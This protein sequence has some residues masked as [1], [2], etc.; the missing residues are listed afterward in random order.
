M[1]EGNDQ[2]GIGE[3]LAEVD[4]FA[5]TLDA[6]AA[7]YWSL[8]RKRFAWLA[9]FSCRTAPESS[10]YRLLDVGNSFQTVLLKALLPY[11]QVDTLGFY[12]HRFSA[13]EGSRH[14]EMDLNDAYY[15]EKWPSP[16]GDGYDLIVFAEV[17]EHLYTS[18]EQVLNCLKQLLR[19]GGRILVQTPNAAALKKRLRLL[20]GRNPYELIRLDRGNP[21]HFREL[22][23][24]DLKRYALGCGLQVEGL[25]LDSNLVDGKRFDRVCDR[26]SRW[27]PGRWRGGISMSLQLGSA[28]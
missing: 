27:L 28:E 16:E 23:V 17:I 18:P 5:S 7:R 9:E 6:E 26:I 20:S 15:P 13:G 1:G 2:S 25:W 22:T 21:G 14:I 12:D 24:A 10:D 4:R 3:A 11:S 19:P 8:H